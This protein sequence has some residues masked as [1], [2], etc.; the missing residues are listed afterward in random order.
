MG[1]VEVGRTCSTDGSYSGRFMKSL[2]YANTTSS[3]R[4][5]TDVR[6]ALIM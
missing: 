2:R 5:T 4:F 1:P 6:R 3:G